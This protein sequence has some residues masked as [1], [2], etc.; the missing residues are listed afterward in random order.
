MRPLQSSSI[1]L[2]Q[3]STEP[4][5][6]A[7]PS[8]AAVHAPFV[9]IWLALHATALPQL[10]V[11]SHVWT[12]SPMHCVV[13]GVHTPPQLPAEHA[14]W[15]GAGLPQLPVMSHVCTALPEHW[16]VPATQAPTQVPPTHVWFVQA[17]ALP[18]APV[19]SHTS[20]PLPEHC[21]APGLQATHA[22]FK[23]AGRLPVQVNGLLQLPVP[24]HDWTPL[25]LPPSPLHWVAPG[26]HT[27][28][29]LPPLQ[30]KAHC[31]GLPHC[32]P[33]QVSRALFEH[34]VA[35]AAQGPAHAPLVHTLG[36]AHAAPEPC[37]VPVPS[38]IWG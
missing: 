37:H 5:A 6:S 34:W 16:V 19:P 20:T 36:L 18:H 21:T 30:T 13:P 35:P 24:S 26:K 28:P 11:P 33:A 22:P 23:Q 14:N 38:Q 1:P 4:Q 25:P 3:I 8:S 10:P 12:P 9:H 27:P 17:V 29:Q 2:S 31:I 7:P 15:Q 32:P